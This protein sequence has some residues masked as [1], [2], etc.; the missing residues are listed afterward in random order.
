VRARP[1]EP[2]R[3]NVGM[4]PLD[5]LEAV[6]ACP[7]CGGRRR[8][9]IYSGLRDRLSNAPGEWTLKRCLACESAY[10]DPRATEAS[11]KRA[12]P[13]DY[14][15]HSRPTR[16]TTRDGPVRRQW[17]KLRHGYLNDRWGYALH[18]ESAAGRFVV[19]LLPHARRLD[20]SV[21]RLR[22]PG[23]DGRV[24]DLGCGHGGFLVYMRELGWRAEGLD[25]DSEA[26][27]RACEAGVDARVG[28]ADHL[29]A[30]DGPYDAITLHHVIEHIHDP[31]KALARIRERLKPGGTLWIATPNVNAPGHGMFGTNWIALDTPRHLIL[32][33]RAGLTELLRSCGFHRI[34][35]EP[36]GTTSAAFILASSQSLALG[37]HPLRDATPASVSLRLR[38]RVAQLRAARKRR[39]A[40]EELVVTA[41]A[42]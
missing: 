10:L 18:P 17:V 15:T 19:P 11:M 31:A 32:L 21:R 35:N 33:S 39:F 27:A 42:G 6:E 38:Y 41:T 29:T 14:P 36:P 3:T 30:E 7:A 23:P 22:F 24:L 28:T 12:Y 34:R 4:W 16:P 37:R 40:G 26:V 8:E 2:T 13:P 20:E 1:F 9:Q 5:E 25:P